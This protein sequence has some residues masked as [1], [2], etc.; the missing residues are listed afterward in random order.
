MQLRFPLP[1]LA[2]LYLHAL[3]VLQVC[4][5]AAAAPALLPGTTETFT[6]PQQSDAAAAATSRGVPAQEGFTPTHGFPSRATGMVLYPSMQRADF[7][8]A[9]ST[10][11]V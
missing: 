7:L 6:S 3:L 2:L 9:V 10:V 5:A 4:Q 1:E 8:L 11:S